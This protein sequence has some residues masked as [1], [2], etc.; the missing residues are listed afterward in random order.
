MT[1]NAFINFNKDRLSKISHGFYS[2]L[3]LAGLVSALMLIQGCSSSSS[4]GSRL[5]HSGVYGTGPGHTKPMPQQGRVNLSGVASVPIRYESTQNRGCNRDYNVLGKDY[6]VW[7]GM[8]SYIEEGTASWYGPGFNGRKTSLGEIYD[9]KGLSAAHKNLPLPS[10]LKVTNLRNGKKLVLRVNDRGPFSGQRILDLSEGAAKYLGV[11]G[12]G[13]A[14]V[15]LEYLDVGPGGSVR[16]AEGSPNVV[17]GSSAPVMSP[18]SS[19]GSSDGSFSTVEGFSGKS[20]W[21]NSDGWISFDNASVAPRARPVSSK[22]VSGAA[23]GAYSGSGNGTRSSSASAAAELPA[24]LSGIFV[25]MA[26]TSDESKAREICAMMARRLNTGVRVATAGGVSRVLAGP[27][28]NE[29]AA[30]EALSKARSLGA[31]DSFIRRF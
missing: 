2:R 12:P 3:L 20:G 17:S 15:R 13:T 18:S 6:E 10:Y 30:R 22:P 19:S 7:N 1:S 25:Q 24:N 16:N 11:I 23:A 29:S 9:Q 14:K 4:G 31:P 28:Q 8:N 26:A 21:V 27:Y 5:G